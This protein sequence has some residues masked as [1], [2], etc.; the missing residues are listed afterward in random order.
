MGLFD[1]S[2][3]LYAKSPFTTA[4]VTYLPTTSS[5]L[6]TIVEDTASAL[7]VLVVTLSAV[8]FFPNSISTANTGTSIVLGAVSS[9]LSALSDGPAVQEATETS[10]TAVISIANTRKIILFFIM[11]LL[12]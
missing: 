8:I 9:L 12:I 3:P 7:M 4:T 2:F 5:R 11:L 10:I 6:V 1:E